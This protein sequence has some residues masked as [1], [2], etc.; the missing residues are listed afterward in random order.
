MDRR[1]WNLPVL[2]GAG[3]AYG[4]AGA[5]WISDLMQARAALD[6]ATP[7]PLGPGGPLGAVLTLGAAFWTVLG[8]RAQRPGP[9]MVLSYLAAGL[10][11]FI[12]A[13]RAIIGPLQWAIRTF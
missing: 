6:A 13:A 12:L 8:L 5:F 11:V 2:V 3:I 9:G 10:H 4:I 1:S 7:E